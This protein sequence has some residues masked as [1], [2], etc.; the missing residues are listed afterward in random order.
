[1]GTATAASPFLTW[2]SQWG[3][4]V[5]IFTQMVFW[6]AIAAA[7]LIVAFQ[8]KRFV[9]YKTGATKPEAKAVREKPA[10]VP[11]ESVVD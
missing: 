3:Q 6:V 2:F 11:I 8:Y 1:M 4:V 5:Y 7:A 10:D 9:A